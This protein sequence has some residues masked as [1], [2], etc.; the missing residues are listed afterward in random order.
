MKTRAYVWLF[1]ASLTAACSNPAGSNACR[2]GADCASGICLPDGTCS[3]TEAD[4]GVDDAPPSTD[5]PE[6]CGNL[7]G[8]ITRDEAPL[9][10]GLMATYRVGI[11]TS[12]STAGTMN[13]DGSRTWDLTTAMAGDHDVHFETKSIAG[14]WFAEA[15]PTATF[16]SRLNADGTLLGVYQATPTALLL[17]G[18]VSPA[19]G[20]GRTELTYDPPVEVKRYPLASNDSWTELADVSGLAAGF[21]AAYSETFDVSVDAA[22]NAVTPAGTY[23]VLRVR[24]VVT[25]TVGIVDTILRTYQLDA[26]CLGSVATLRANDNESE[27]E[28][29]NAAEAWRRGP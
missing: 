12:V 20:L 19:G 24:T 18:V 28:F 2:V 23:P 25:R 9:D 27:V 29:T 7:D 4:G 1:A 10:A 22:G 8:T 5:A 15:F 11:E 13:P 3:S 16:A 14:T 26:E 6:S 21:V 17:V